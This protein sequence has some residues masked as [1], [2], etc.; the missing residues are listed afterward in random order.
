M[1]L[2][3]KFTLVVLLALMALFIAL[4]PSL[5]KGMES[6]TPS[7]LKWTVTRDISKG[8]DLAGGVELDYK[9]DTT[10]VPADKKTQILQGVKNVI[11]TRVDALGLSEPDIVLS[12]IGNEDHIK[13]TLAG[14]KNV[15]QAKKTIGKTIQL[16]FKVPKPAEAKEDTGAI[17]NEATATLAAVKSTPNKFTFIAEEKALSDTYKVTQETKDMFFDELPQ[18]FRTKI[19]DTKIGDVVN[20]L[21]DNSAAKDGTQSYIV[22]KLN[23]VNTELRKN[24]KNAKS[25]AEVAKKYNDA[26]LAD[27]GYVQLTG[28]SIPKYA[29]NVLSGESELGSGQISDVI[30]TDQGNV[31]LSVSDKAI[32]SA[33]EQVS[34]AHI[35]FKVPSAIPLKEVPK[36]AKDSDKKSIED[37]NKKIQDSNKKID[38]QKI[39]VKAKAQDIAK[40]LQVHPEK[41]S[42]YAKK[43]SEDD[44]N[45]QS[46][47]MLGFFG[48]GAMVKEF[49]EAAFSM[50]DG[51]VSNIIETSFGYHIIRKNATKPANA[52]VAHLEQVIV[53]YK[54]AASCDKATRTK[55]EAKIR[56]NEALKEL[57]EEK[58]Y[59]ISQIIYSTIADPWMAAVVEG[60]RLTGEYFDLADVQYYTNRLDP[61]VSIKFNKEG[62]DLFEKITD[63]YK[64]QNVAIF[65]GGKL[66]SAPKVNDKISGGSAIIEG[67]FTPKDAVALARDLN[68]GA[69]PAPISIS[70]EEIVGAE[71]GADALNKSLMAGL[72]GFL[73]LGV[74]L[75]YLYRLSGLIAMFALCVYSALFI[76]FTK[77]LPGFNLT[78]SSAAA[79]IL[80]IG[81]AVDGNVLIFERFKEELL[82][83]GT[84][85]ANIKKAFERAWPA[86]RDSHVSSIITALLLF[87]IG[88][89]QVK[90]FAI[91]L[92]VGIIMSLFTAVWVTRI[93]MQLLATT[94]FGQK[95][96]PKG[97]N[98]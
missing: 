22:A 55:E 4:P 68:T 61:V 76:A 34:A 2:K 1:S 53:C 15:D 91:F 63:K 58:K 38:A 57:R 74:Y 14:V 16:E 94:Q 43:Y 11:H 6:F 81:M 10:K 12:T 82:E 69:I 9:V 23:A 56:A 21:I 28:A 66:I 80:S 70:G 96:L 37:E 83:G 90:G 92:L 40:D 71:L 48:K 79:I 47:G 25:F 5:K 84:V 59:N 39:V 75:T 19:T 87:L 24:P 88:T 17:K 89:D 42:E 77:I 32:V 78:L 3:G 50:K 45:S 13:V 41:F 86:I 46:G 95:Y 51:S 18:A 33:D 44:S 73:I 35:L 98:K 67:S 8:L 62:G 27:F 93:S 65:V 29:Q 20:E 26:S 52:G 60:K 72:L 54:G 36:D 49:E 64:G 7:F 97:M 31:I 85:A 30:E